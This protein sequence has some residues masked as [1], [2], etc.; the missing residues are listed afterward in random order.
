MLKSKRAVMSSHVCKSWSPFF[1][2]IKAGKKTHDLRDN[3]DRNFAVG[4]VITLRE[5][6]PFGGGYTGEELKVEITYMTSRENPC[7][8]SSAVL[9]RDYVILSLKRQRV[10]IPRPP[11]GGC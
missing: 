4:D 7:A 2:A 10:S 9:D 8:F 5:F 6:D 3:T 11:A 1:Q